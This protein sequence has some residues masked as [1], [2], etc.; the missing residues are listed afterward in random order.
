MTATNPKD[1]AFQNPTEEHGYLINEQPINYN[2]KAFT[3]KHNKKAKT[4]MDLRIA[5]SMP[6]SID[7]L[8]TKQ[9]LFN[10]EMTH[11]SFDCPKNLR[12][13]L[14]NAV[15]QNGTS[16]CKILC[17]YS[18]AYVTATMIKKHAL[19]NTKIE[20]DRKETVV[21][22]AIG[23]LS[24]TQ[25][26]QNRPRRIVNCNSNAIVNDSE[27]ENRCMIGSCKN[28]ATS[29]MIY[30]PKG[31]VAKEYQVCA[32]HSSELVNTSPWSFKR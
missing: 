28:E 29:V 11:L 32:Y 26:V 31:K 6:F 21:N 25:N 22:V 20:P 27:L 14:N 4:T 2:P 24:F 10:G 18:V 8:A 16:V 1:L 17:E 15:K 7:D 3:T 5:E 9:A 19:A 12:T 13:A 30:H 23:E